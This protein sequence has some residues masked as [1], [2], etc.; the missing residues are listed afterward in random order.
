MIVAEM[1]D[2]IPPEDAAEQRRGDRRIIGSDAAASGRRGGQA[3][4]SRHSGQVDRL[5]IGLP[6]VACVIIA[7]VLVWPQLVPNEKSFRLSAVKIQPQ[8][9][10][11]LSMTNARFVGTDAER[12]PYVVTATN[13]IEGSID[14]DHVDLTEPKADMTQTDGT[15]VLGSGATGV[16]HR[17]T[18][19]LDLKG[20]V[21]VFHDSGAEFHTERA[22]VDLNTHDVSGDD[23]VNGQS[24]SATI[25]SE[26]FRIRERGKVVLFT[27]KAHLILRQGAGG[28]S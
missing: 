22:H 1:T 27:G 18:R 20:D 8:E 3:T 11:T 28:K 17:D 2:T 9:A 12:R 25:T 4:T 5:K 13:A 19:S 10:E 15:W 16:Y 26:G 23:P 7:L 24:P 6:V 14:A 21:T